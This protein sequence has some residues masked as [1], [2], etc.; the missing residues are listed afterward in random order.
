M[1]YLGQCHTSV[2]QVT[3]LCMNR[4][5]FLEYEPVFAR[6]CGAEI[7][8]SSVVLLKRLK[9]KTAG[10]SRCTSSELKV[11]QTYSQAKNKQKQK[12]E[13][14]YT[15]SKATFSTKENVHNT[16]QLVRIVQDVQI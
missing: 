3:Q 16:A 5:E 8:I 7:E 10:N 13:K 9:K 11:K 14:K 6:I 1:K 4:N 12:R 15:Y 2:L